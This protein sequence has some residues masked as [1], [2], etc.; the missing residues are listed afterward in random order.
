MASPGATPLHPSQPMEMVHA[1]VGRLVDIALAMRQ[2]MP[3][4]CS[5]LA[6]RVSSSESLALP[7]ARVVFNSGSCFTGK[8]VAGVTQFDSRLLAPGPSVSSRFDPISPGTRPR[9][10][11]S[12]EIDV[13][14]CAR[15]EAYNR[16]RQ[17]CAPCI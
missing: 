14:Q 11:Q 13:F 9:C 2:L 7:A 6:L 17:G 1:S 15:P 10:R 8:S 5:S 3:Q 16:R 12:T 4:V